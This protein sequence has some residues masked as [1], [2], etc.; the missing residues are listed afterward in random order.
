MLHNEILCPP[1]EPEEIL[2]IQYADH[3]INRLF[4]DRIN[5]VAAVVNGLLP[6]LQRLIRPQKPDVCPMRGKLIHCHV[7]KFKQ[8]LDDLIFLQIDHTF[9]A[10]GICHFPY[11]FLA[12]FHRLRIWIDPE[13]T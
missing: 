6:L 7:I 9:F 3:M 8:I 2:D 10:S 12:D 5:G 4:A 1:A 13:K 11:L